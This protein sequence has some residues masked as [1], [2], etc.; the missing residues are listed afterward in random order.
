MKKLSFKLIVFLI[1]VFSIG[2]TVYADNPNIIISP[3]TL[4]GVEGEPIPAD[5]VYVQEVTMSNA[6]LLN[7]YITNK[8]N[9]VLTKFPKESGRYL[10]MDKATKKSVGFINLEIKKPEVIITTSQ[11]FKGEFMF[12]QDGNMFKSL[13]QA[14]DGILYFFRTNPNPNQTRPMILNIGTIEEGTLNPQ[15]FI[16]VENSTLKIKR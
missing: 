12:Y 3:T 2:I 16:I 13:K 14:K 11:D 15:K 1:L 4:E 8:N 9:Q 7:V 10:L 6:R 5:S